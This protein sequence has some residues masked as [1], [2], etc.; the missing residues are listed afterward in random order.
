MRGGCVLKKA[1]SIL[2]DVRS[3]CQ[4]SKKRGDCCRAMH[5]AKGLKG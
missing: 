2:A 5:G 4:G 3:E 1:D